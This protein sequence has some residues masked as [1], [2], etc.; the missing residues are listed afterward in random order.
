MFAV[1]S[2]IYNITFLTR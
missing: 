2:I 1:M